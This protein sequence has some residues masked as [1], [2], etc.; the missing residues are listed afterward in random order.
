[1]DEFQRLIRNKALANSL[2][3]RLM[4]ESR[5]DEALILRQAGKHPLSIYVP[6]PKQDI[7]H[8]SKVQIRIVIGGN[9]SGKTF[10]GSSEFMMRMLKIHLHDK[11]WNKRV[12]PIHGLVLVEDKMQA[13]Q[14]GASQSK[15]LSMLPDD[16]VSNIKFDRGFLEE[17]T[18]NDGSTFMVRSSR[19][20]RASL[21][22]SRLDIIW[23]DEDCIK[24]SAM[25]DELIFRISDSGLPPLLLITYTPNLEDAKESF[26]DTV[27]L[28]RVEEPDGKYDLEVHQFSIFDNPHVPDSTKQFLLN[29][30]AGDSDQVSARFDG[31]GKK[32]HGL[33]YKSFGKRHIIPPISKEYIKSHCKA[34]F[35]IIDPHPVKPIAVSFI[36]CFDDGRVI[37]FNELGEPGIVREVAKRIRTVCDG[38]GHLVAKSIL[39]YSGNASNNINGVST[40]DEFAA[41]GIVTTN[42]VKDVTMGINFVK[43]ML[44]FSDGEGH[45]EGAY[46]PTF[47]IT[48]NCIK[49]I[50]EFSKYREDP[51]TNMPAKKHD[52]YM[53][54]LRYFAC[55]SEAKLYYLKE[56]KKNVRHGIRVI[57]EGVAKEI[58]GGNEK[59][60]RIR[61]RQ[62]RVQ[63]SIGPGIGRK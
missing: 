50:R 4:R 16:R 47:F 33:I 17:V 12:G 9:S 20:G 27:L 19:A 54:N 41:C 30:T 36:G 29:N 40:K 3:D 31:E 7:F 44:Q 8:K 10:V 62:N 49:T 43:E 52:E 39:D 57:I 53:D 24:D 1:M 28:P 48:S 58:G 60:K 14:H 34:I 15:I 63:D 35:R 11:E 56:R 18:F 59:D 38:I 6:T 46:E 32:K 26:T 51:K 42:C 55:D 5:A 37:Q 21:Q 45:P 22:G 61:A 13:C 23:V 25:F 2:A